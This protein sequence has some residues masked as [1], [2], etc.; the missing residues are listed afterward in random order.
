MFMVPI[1]G[2]KIGNLPLNWFTKF[3]FISIMGQAAVFVFGSV[4]T[5]DRANFIYPSGLV[6][7]NCRVHFC[8]IIT[9]RRDC[10]FSFYNFRSL[11]SYVTSSLI[12][13]ICCLCSLIL[14]NMFIACFPT[15]IHASIVGRRC[16]GIYRYLIWSTISARER[17][18]F[19][20]M[21]ESSSEGRQ[22]GLWFY[23]FVGGVVL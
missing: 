3:R 16:F 18:F 15:S 9:V 12:R 20:V 4:S 6:G 5:D 23:R 10:V 14:T 21:C 17:R 1:I 8:P 22:R 13:D 19:Y 11:I 2:R 7:D